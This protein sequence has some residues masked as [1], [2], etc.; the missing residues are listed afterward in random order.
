ML[1]LHTLKSLDV[2][3]ASVI[4]ILEKE[5]SLV[6]IQ[7]DSPGLRLLRHKCLHSET[8]IQD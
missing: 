5:N 7:Y 8:L 1:E 3:C 6:C 2:T 4:K